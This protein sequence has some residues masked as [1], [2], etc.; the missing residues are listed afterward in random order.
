MIGDYSS[1]L[2]TSIMLDQLD[3][4]IDCVLIRWE[5]LLID[6]LISEFIAWLPDWMKWESNIIIMSR[7]VD[8]LIS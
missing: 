4:F 6:W 2:P 8:L 3:W 7:L 5:S 1:K